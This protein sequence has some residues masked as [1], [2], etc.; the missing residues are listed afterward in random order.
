M[1][2]RRRKGLNRHQKAVFKGGDHRVRG[3]GIQCL[4]EM[5]SSEDPAERLHA[6]ENLCP[7]HVRRRVEAAWEALY[8]L[9]Q[10]PDVRVRRAAWHTLE[11]GGCPDDPAL[12]PIFERAVANETDSQVRRWVERFAAPALSE[13][14]RQEALR[15]AYTPFQEYGRCDFC[16]EKGRRVRKEY[17]TELTGGGGLSRLAQI[18]QQCDR[19]AS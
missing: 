15:A 14:D 16:G 10:D 12:L 11:D 6:A 2:A 18:C 3:E 19:Q 4:I 9:M 1:K 17:E 7:C 8:R 5:A 13:R